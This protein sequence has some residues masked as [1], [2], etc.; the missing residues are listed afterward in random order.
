MSKSLKPLFLGE[1][2][3]NGGLKYENQEKLNYTSLS[4]QL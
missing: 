4:L 1:G 2:A 3:L